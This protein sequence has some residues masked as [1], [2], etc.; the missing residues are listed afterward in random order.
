MRFSDWNLVCLPNTVLLRAT[1]YPA[2]VKQKMGIRSEE[3]SE[4]IPMYLVPKQF[5][6]IRFEDRVNLG[7]PKTRETIKD[8][9][10]GS[11]GELIG[12]RR[13]KPQNKA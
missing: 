13:V 7:E 12:G 11:Q 8:R 2:W 10:E 9:R 5:D 1:I 4:S 3:M 6:Q